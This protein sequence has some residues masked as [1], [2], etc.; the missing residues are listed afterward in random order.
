MVRRNF[1]PNRLRAVILLYLTITK[2]YRNFRYEL[3]LIR[4]SK[5][6]IYL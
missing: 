4:R 3:F 2:Q 6:N 5:L 1:N